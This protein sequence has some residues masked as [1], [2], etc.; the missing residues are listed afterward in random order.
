MYLFGNWTWEL[1]IRN[2]QLA[3]ILSYK[4]WKKGY[5]PKIRW[6][7]SYAAINPHLVLTV[8]AV[9]TAW[10]RKTAYTVVYL[11]TYEDTSYGLIKEC[12]LM[13]RLNHRFYASHKQILERKKSRVENYLQK[14]KIKKQHKNLRSRQ[15]P[16]K[17]LDD[18]QKRIV[19]ALPTRSN[20]KPRELG[21]SSS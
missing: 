8:W 5:F 2:E 21:S 11:I 18:I 10:Q 14:L 9:K 20:S 19:R 17:S 3:T 1:T 4:K 7:L 13:D 15:K 6:L 12:K 16:C